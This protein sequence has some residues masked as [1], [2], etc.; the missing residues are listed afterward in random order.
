[1]SSSAVSV[2]GPGQT[3]FTNLGEV[4]TSG[5]D[6]VVWGVASP[7]LNTNLVKLGAGAAINAHTNHEVDVLVIVRSGTGVATIDGVDHPIAAAS[8]VLIPA[9][10]ERLVQATTDLIYLSIHQRRSGPTIGRQTTS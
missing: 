6:G 4:D 10:A 9:G 8:A 7:Q 1:M 2:I 5:P 3:L